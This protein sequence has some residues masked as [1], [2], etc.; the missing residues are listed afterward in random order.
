[1]E[2]T[3]ASGQLFEAMLRTLDVAVVVEDADGRVLASNP[4]AVRILG[5]DCAAMHEDGWPLPEGA[6]PAGGWPLPE[7]ARPASVALQSGRPCTG[8]TIGLKRP[9]GNV[10]WVVASAHPLF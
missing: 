4:M 10:T 6:R 8:V 3:L 2:P 1:M 5:P 9:G 7:E